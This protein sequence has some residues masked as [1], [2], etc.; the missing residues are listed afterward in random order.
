MVTAQSWISYQTYRFYWNQKDKT[1]KLN[2]T[3]CIALYF[4][5]TL[6]ILITLPVKDVY[7]H[8]S[9]LVYSSYEYYI[10]PVKVFFYVKREIQYSYTYMYYVGFL[11]SKSNYQFS[12]IK[13]KSFP[14]HSNGINKKDNNTYAWKSFL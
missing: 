5:S 4:L 2:F 10:F 9:F 14:N 6:H 8:D 11:Q 7:A 3:W 13:T 12:Y 1:L